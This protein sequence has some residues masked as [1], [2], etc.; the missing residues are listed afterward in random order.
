[1]H[2]D[3]L[4]YYFNK[5]FRKITNNNN[6]QS[7][8]HRF[9]NERALRFFTKLYKK[10]CCSF[11][12]L[13]YLYALIYNVWNL[14]ISH[15]TREQSHERYIMMVLYRGLYMYYIHQ[16]NTHSIMGCSANTICF[17][18]FAI[19]SG[20]LFILECPPGYYGYNC[21]NHCSDHCSVP[22]T[23][24]RVTGRC[25]GGCMQGWTGD[26]CHGK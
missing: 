8:Y 1:M 21:F 16:Y 25:N 10:I 7:S 23:C 15:N 17:Q 4:S 26:T 9:T 2:I 3:N 12:Q 20:V 5:L 24:D 11:S 19:V 18:M 13:N 22:F 6:F 14:I